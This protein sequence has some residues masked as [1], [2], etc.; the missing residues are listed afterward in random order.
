MSNNDNYNHNQHDGTDNNDQRLN[1]VHGGEFRN[2]R[3]SQI[4]NNNP[5]GEDIPN[6]FISTNEHR[7]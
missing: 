3:K 2:G 1:Q 6:E 7:D 5:D 4:K